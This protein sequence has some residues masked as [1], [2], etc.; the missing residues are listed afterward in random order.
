[1]KKSK[2]WVYQILICGAMLSV[3]GCSS[4]KGTHTLR[5]KGLEYRQAKEE[6][7]VDFSAMPNASSQNYR[8]KVPTI[9]ANANTGPVNLAPVSSG[10]EDYIGA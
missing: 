1:M 9:S 4:I 8:Y 6:A 10:I 7:T 5:H 3:M 2:K